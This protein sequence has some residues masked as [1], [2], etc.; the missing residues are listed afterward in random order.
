VQQLIEF[1][2]NHAM[3]AIGFVGVI[4]FLIWTEISRYT[5]GYAELTPAEAVRKINAGK[6]SIVDISTTADFSKGN[7]AS[8][9]HVAL[10][11]FSQ[12]DPEIEALK[13]SPVLLVCKNGQTAN[14]AAVRLVKLGATDV[15]ILKGG[16]TQWKADQFP[17]V[18][19]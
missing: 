5:R 4:L 7:L 8:A 14:Q 3:L 15:A 18:R 16:N 1:A 13:S 17:L 10:S 6:I 9:K 12:P 11:R 2:G 19:K